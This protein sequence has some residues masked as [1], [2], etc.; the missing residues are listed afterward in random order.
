M[1]QPGTRTRLP[2]GGGLTLRSVATPEDAAHFAAF[3]TAINDATQG[4]TCAAL[5]ARFPGMTGVDFLLVEETA[6]GEVVSTSCL[7]PW[8]V[9][10]GGCTLEVAMLEMVATHPDY[11]RRGLV[12]RQ[13]EHFHAVTAA[14][15]FDLCMIEGIGYFYRQFGYAYAGD[16]WGDDLLAASQVPAQVDG[17]SLHLR[18]ATAD[19]IPLLMRL[20]AATTD[21]LEVATVR[22]AAGWRYL[23]DGAAYPVT[24]LNDATTQTPLGYVAGW[25]RDGLYRIIEHGMPAASTALALLAHLRR[26]QPG[27]MVLGWPVQSTLLDVARTLG[28]K[29]A[30][31][32]QWLWRWVDL[33]ALLRKL[34]PV[35]A[36]RLAAS[37]YAGL[38][39]DLILN[40]FTTA[41]GLRFEDGK[42][43]A[44]DALG[45]VDAS[46]GA[47][48]GDLCIPPE[49]FMRLLLGYRPL[50]ALFDAWPDI[51][52]RKARR[53]LWDVLWP[54]LDGYVWMPYVNLA[55]EEPIA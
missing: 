29:P 19:D 14:R 12:R 1:V 18:P 43:V 22:E 20:A 23:L 5:Y 24:L 25:K 44:V 2:L 31:G 47:D 39:A 36:E 13:I 41:Y 34:A 54:R 17:P 35:L 40:L 53:G 9:R 50:D 7:I 27:D 3:N 46:M 52:V 10:L 15:G 38:R 21:R 16:H 49:A 32:D 26:T 30:W 48:G 37:P 11:R 51:A 6:T 33:P 4:A 28:S 55:E 42:L 8:Q 45:F